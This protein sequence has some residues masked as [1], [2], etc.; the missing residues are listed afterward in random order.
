MKESVK[1]VLKSGVIMEEAV[2]SDK[3]LTRGEVEKSAEVLRN[4]IGEAI[5][6]KSTGCFIV[7]NIVFN[8]QEIAAVEIKIIED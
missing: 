3:D 5:K 2:D 6:Q 1:I 8:I 7:G 4:K